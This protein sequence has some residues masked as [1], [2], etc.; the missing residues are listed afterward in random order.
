MTVNKNCLFNTNNAKWATH[1]LT[2]GYRNPNLEFSNSDG[3]EYGFIINDFDEYP[4]I[5]QLN[6]QD[7]E[8]L[9]IKSYSESLIVVGGTCQFVSWG[10]D[11]KDGYIAFDS[12]NAY[13]FSFKDN[14]YD[15]SLVYA[16]ILNQNGKTIPIYLSETPP[17]WY[18]P[19]NRQ[20]LELPWVYNGYITSTKLE[21][22]YRW[23]W[24]LRSNNKTCSGYVWY[25][26]RE[27][28]EYVVS[29]DISILTGPAESFDFPINIGTLLLCIQGL[30]SQVAD[31]SLS[32]ISSGPANIDSEMLKPGLEF[33]SLDDEP[34]KIDSP[35]IRYVDSQVINAVDYWL[36]IFD[37]NETFDVKNVFYTNSWTQ[38]KPQNE[39]Y[40]IT[41]KVKR[42]VLSKGLSIKRMWNSFKQT[43]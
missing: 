11:R 17:S 15:N 28:F 25:N 39:S 37:L 33:I 43:L 40:N 38:T 35:T 4:G 26:D 16:N 32:D 5:G 23:D 1:Q 12:E 21:N 30:L 14:L 24:Q 36:S 10:K 8:K 6:P 29:G 27:K 19:T 22:G 34:V 9:I 31:K 41:N 2:V 20:R 7:T 42:F 3:N 13:K 18:S